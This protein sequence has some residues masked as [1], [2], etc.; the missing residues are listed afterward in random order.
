MTV[1]EDVNDCDECELMGVLIL[2]ELENYEATR[3]RNSFHAPSRLP[4]SL[5][6]ELREKVVAR[7]AKMLIE[8][9]RQRS[10]QMRLAL[11]KSS[12]I[13]ARCKA[14]HPVSASPSI[15]HTP[16]R[17]PDGLLEENRMKA[18]TQEAKMLF[19]RVGQGP[20]T[21]RVM[22]LLVIFIFTSVS[23]RK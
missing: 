2:D 21:V 7:E 19:L 22:K 17:L 8:D 18:A 1:S 9:S 20:T 13:W 10:A 4:V 3:D 16:R 15:I 14:V 6:G 12:K 5:L 11:S 23:H